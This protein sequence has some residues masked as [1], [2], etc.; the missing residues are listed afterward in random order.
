MIIATINIKVIQEKRAELLQTLRSMTKQILKEKGCNSCDFY[1]D[2]ENENAFILTEEWETQEDVDNHIKSDM[3]CA[4]L[5][6]KNL[7]SESPEIKFKV[8]SYAAGME[9]VEKV[10]EESSCLSKKE[11]RKNKK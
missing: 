11:K 1:Q 4:L 5:G 8:V 2:V 7:L 6:T 9:A 3:F 10:R